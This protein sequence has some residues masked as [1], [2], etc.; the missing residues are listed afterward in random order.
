MKTISHVSLI[1]NGCHTLEPGETVLARLVSQDSNGRAIITLVTELDEPDLEDVETLAT[2]A[3]CEA[4][5]ALT[6][7]FA[8]A[9]KL[10]EA[11]AHFKAC[12]EACVPASTA[13]R[14]AQNAFEAACD[15]ERKA[16][17][18]VDDW[19]GDFLVLAREG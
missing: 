10:R 16:R 7:L 13:R 19:L 2:D 14:A 11:E 6:P 3:C 18:A 15:A 4:P 8:A 9:V 12:R 17:L 1:P 5:R